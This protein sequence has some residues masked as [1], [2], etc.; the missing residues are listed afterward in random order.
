MKGWF[1]RLPDQERG[2]ML[3]MKE[4]LTLVVNPR[5]GP[6]CMRGPEASMSATACLLRET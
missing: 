4:I 1:Q 2:F 6:R 5:N 3:A